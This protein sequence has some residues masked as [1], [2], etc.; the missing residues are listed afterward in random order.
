MLRKLSEKWLRE[1]LM[2]RRFHPKEGISSVRER[3]NVSLY[4]SFAITPV[5]HLKTRKSRKLTRETV[6]LVHFVAF[7]VSPLTLN[8]I[9]RCVYMVVK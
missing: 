5:D 6:K 9:P 2:V 8:S 3:F 4:R 7:T 1:V